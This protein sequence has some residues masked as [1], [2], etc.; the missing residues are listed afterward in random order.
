MSL[1]RLR[2][3]PTRL[4]SPRGA[5]LELH[6]D[7]LHIDTGESWSRIRV[8]RSSLLIRIE[9]YRL[10]DALSNGQAMSHEKEAAMVILDQSSG[11][12]RTPQA[13]GDL[14]LHNIPA[15]EYL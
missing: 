2:S 8:R 6:E 4:E 14:K 13:G 3:S 12:A 9:R 1:R 5:V 11:T 7:G 15:G 10:G